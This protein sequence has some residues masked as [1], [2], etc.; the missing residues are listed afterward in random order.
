MSRQRHCTLFIAIKAANII[1]MRSDMLN[2]VAPLNLARAIFCTIRRNLVWACVYNL[3][4]IPRAMGLFLPLGVHLHPMM[5]G[6]MMGFS[7]VSVVTS[8]SL[9]R[10]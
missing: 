8:S 9:L 4:G 6:A 3:L 2:V 7:S 1:L 10:R 5:A